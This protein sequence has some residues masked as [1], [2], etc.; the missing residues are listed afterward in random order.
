MN[1]HFVGKERDL[2]K[3]W[4]TSLAVLQWLELVRGE[5]AGAGAGQSVPGGDDPGGGALLL[6]LLWSALV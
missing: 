3:R 5:R 6:P 4:G 2:D 1:F